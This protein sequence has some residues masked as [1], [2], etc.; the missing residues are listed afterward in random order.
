MTEEP[1]TIRTLVSPAR[2]AML[3]TAGIAT[4]AGV[5]NVMPY[6]ALTEIARILLGENP[7]TYL[8]HWVAF[9]AITLALSQTAYGLGLAITH[10]AEAKLR[11]TLRHRLVD[12]FGHI[13]LGAIDQT[14]SGMIRK[15]VVDDTATIHTLVAHLSG[16]LVFALTSLLSGMIYLLWVDWQLAVM[17]LTMWTIAMGVTM[18]LAMRDYDTLMSNFSAKQTALAAASVEM[19]EG[20]K[21]IRN[22]QNAELG[23][24]R[25]HS[26]RKAFSDSSFAWSDTA[27]RFTAISTSLLSP[28]S[29]F[30]LLVP[31]V[32]WFSS[33]GW[34]EPSYALPFLIIAP[35]LPMGLQT[36][37][38]LSQHLYEA[39]RAAADTA[40]LLSLPSLA[41]SKESAATTSEDAVCF[42][43]VTFGY[44]KNTLVIENL[45]LR[46]PRGK[47]TALVG[48]SGGGK[49]TLAKLIARFYDVS[50]GVVR[51]GGQD[52]RS[53]TQSELLSQIAIVFQDVALAHDTITQ[54]IA[55]GAQVEMDRVIE[56]AK[57]AQ[58]HDRIMR[59]PSGYET[60][61]DEGAGFL[62]GGE[63][64]RLTIARAFYH[65]API[66]ILDE[67][68]AQADPHSEH[69]I[70]QALSALAAGRTVVIIAHRLKTVAHAHQIAVI[71]DG[72]LVE[73]GTHSE[74]LHRDGA[75][76]TLWKS[77][78]RLEGE[79]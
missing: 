26:A 37:I 49:S 17:L 31:V 13:S 79:H 8:G 1:V 57:K 20:I 15:I 46:I 64:Q 74:L 12:K 72:T 47:V 54:N 60:V 73:C 6:V 45:T 78:H 23:R 4:L 24:T 33:L 51:V 22:F 10:V 38:S 67:A 30:T 70:H 44:D 16:D 59:L 29:V 36:L 43:D 21:E 63:R 55:L 32:I 34:I 77:Q 19:L 75:Y 61:I 50:S 69:Q 18:S 48:P 76:A 62:S 14:S 25:F 35:G 2:R 56:A 28:A 39:R 65:D 53:Q 27:G 3:A 42:E 58:I 11:H 9:G 41:L 7:T 5:A 71:A 66:L 52:V 68:T 40:S